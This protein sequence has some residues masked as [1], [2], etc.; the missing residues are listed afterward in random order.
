MTQPMKAPND[1]VL[2]SGALQGRKGIPVEVGTIL[3]GT[4]PERSRHLAWSDGCP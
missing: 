2:H 1:I 4:V 3:F